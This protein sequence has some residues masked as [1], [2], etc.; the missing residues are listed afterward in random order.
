[1]TLKIALECVVSTSQ[2]PAARAGVGA[3][4]KSEDRD[5]YGLLAEVELPAARGEPHGLGAR[6]RAQSEAE[7]AAWLG[8]ARG[9][10]GALAS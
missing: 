9:A 10:L 6:Y 7:V 2:E 3:L 5:S 1:M 4:A 8:A